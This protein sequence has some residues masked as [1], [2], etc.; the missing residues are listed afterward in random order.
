VTVR[1]KSLS[2]SRDRGLLDGVGAQSPLEEPP[3][4]AP[5]PDEPPFEPLPP[6]EPPAEPLPLEVLSA[7]SLPPADSELELDGPEFAVPAVPSPAPL[8][9]VGCGMDGFV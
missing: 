8:P 7:E 3:S 2:V 4:E 5:E 9:D 6:E 1:A